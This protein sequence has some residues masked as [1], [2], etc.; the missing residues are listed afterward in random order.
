MN[1]R[2]DIDDA[3]Y[4]WLT[5]RFGER[6]AEALIPCPGHA[7]PLDADE[8]KAAHA[9]YERWAEQQTCGASIDAAEYA[10]EER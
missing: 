5:Q 9:H 6:T 1:A 7:W 10:M 3:A 4:E 8:Q 2:E